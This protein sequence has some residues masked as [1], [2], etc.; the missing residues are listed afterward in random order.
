MK[1]FRI[2]GASTI[3]F[4]FK[5]GEV[6]FIIDNDCQITAVVDGEH[7]R[8]EVIKYEKNQLWARSGNTIHHAS[9]FSND[10][11]NKEKIQP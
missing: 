5:E 3:K 11:K 2:S 8:V 9:F 7:F 4:P 1:F 6:D 10:K